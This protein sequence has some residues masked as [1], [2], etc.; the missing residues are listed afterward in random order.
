MANRS[1]TGMAVRPF[2]RN[3]TQISAVVP[4][5][6]ISEMSD[7]SPAAAQSSFLLAQ[8]LQK[9]SMRMED[10]LDIKAQ[11]EATREGREAG[12]SGVPQLQDETTIRGKAFN[13]SARD[14][15]RTEFDLNA[16]LRLDDLEKE[17]T[18]DPV[19]FEE[20]SQAFIA[21]HLSALK[22]QGYEEIA[23]DIGASFEL[24]RRNAFGRIEKRQQALIRDRQIENALH[25]QARAQEEI[26]KA[27]RLLMNAPAHEMG[28]ILNQMSEIS[29]RATET[30][31]HFGPDG[32]PLFSAGQRMNFQE[33]MEE[34]VAQQVGM[35]WLDK[36]P[37]IEEG[38]ESWHNGAAFIEITGENG[39]KGTLNLE[40]ALGLEAA[41]NALP[42]M[43]RAAKT[44]LSA[45]KAAFEKESSVLN[46][47]LDL[48]ITTAT[49]FDA[50]EQISSQID[51]HEGRIGT[52]KANNLRKKIFNAQE[53]FAE[54][55]DD[56]AAG[57]LFARGD[58][59]LNPQD[60]DSKKA[61][62]AFYGAVQTELAD[63]DPA[64]RNMSV[65]Q[66]IANAG[67]VPDLLK[68]DISIAARS[69]DPD[70]IAQAA[71][72]VDRV[73]DKNPHLVDQLGA[74]RDLARIT[75]VND[76]I[77]VGYDTKEAFEAV[78]KQLD[79]RHAPAVEQMDG[80]I[81]TLV[82]EQKID[83]RARAVDALSTFSDD[84]FSLVPFSGDTID[85]G[86][87]DVQGELDVAQAAYRMAWED[88]YRLTRDTGQAEKIAQ[89]KLR[90]QF[91]RSRINGRPRIMRFAPENYYAIDGLSENENAQWMRDQM[92]DEAVKLTKN[93]ASAP[94][95]KDLRKN[96]KLLPVP[97]LTARTAHEGRPVYQL[98]YMKDG[99]IP[100]N[101]LP[102]GQY[103]IFDPGK[104]REDLIEKAKEPEKPL[105][106]FPAG[107]FN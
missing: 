95:R 27:S 100:Q 29:A 87:A 13:A 99:A 66:I 61:F 80:E 20:K 105:R 107:R 15:V 50:L 73:A 1:G 59:T 96:L 30:T 62:N 75:M 9:I 78:D 65:T 33:K 94:E 85:Q 88:A 35:A 45:Q 36:Q 28:D 90:G 81:S 23:Q 22:E 69:R 10:R 67:V 104:A 86:G 3:Q 89:T 79:P 7:A 76:R 14:A 83:F 93:N 37:S 68:G 64:Q 17:F 40:D 63:L 44:K 70:V 25:Y 106:I 11:V 56:I 102:Q 39:E 58:M 91:G 16:R 77:A 82:K 97:S 34:L 42:Y 21:G 51:L 2:K 24:N 46:S 26:I 32:R 48:A 98:V 60:T 54:D 49:D 47:S 92:I 103:F 31:S 19:G 72:L 18:H 71:D 12:L 55:H 6:N 84:F 5:V 101:L 57:A 8:S 38:L 43:E 53:K 74:T 4:R 52:V 41:Q